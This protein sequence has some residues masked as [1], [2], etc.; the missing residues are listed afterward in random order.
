MF[1]LPPPKWCCK[2]N[3]I[4]GALGLIHQ[5]AQKTHPTCHLEHPPKRFRGAGGTWA[6]SWY[7]ELGSMKQLIF[8][9][10]EEERILVGGWT[11]PFEKYSSNW[12]SSPIFGVNIEKYLSCHHL[13]YHRIPLVNS[14]SWLENIAIFDRR[15]IDSNGG[16]PS[17]LC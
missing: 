9:W 6:N 12:E 7:S 17:Q 10:G 11:N 1:E 3:M 8:F 4:K 14:H 16:F 5:S 2:C 13:E 15:Y